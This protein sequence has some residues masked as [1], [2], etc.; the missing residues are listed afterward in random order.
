MRA[1][2]PAWSREWAGTDPPPRPSPAA[3]SVA[4]SSARVRIKPNPCSRPKIPIE[5]CNHQLILPAVSVEIWPFRATS[6]RRPKPGHREGP[7]GPMLVCIQCPLRVTSRRKAAPISMSAFGGKADVN[8]CVGECPLLAISG[9]WWANKNDG[10]GEPDRT[11]H[12]HD[13]ERRASVI[14]TQYD[15]RYTRG[16]PLQ[17]G[18]P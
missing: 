10:S 11:P 4:T 14:G 2:A 12:L 16:H 15:L 5:A 8:H 13:R 3:V 17:G 1:C 18:E 7:I 9:H 6:F